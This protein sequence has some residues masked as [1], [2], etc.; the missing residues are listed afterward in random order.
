M[1]LSSVRGENFLVLSESITGGERG[2]KRIFILEEEKAEGWWEFMEAIYD[3]Q[4]VELV[5]LEWLKGKTRAEAEQGNGEA[6][7]HV[8]CQGII[9][10]TCQCCGEEM[11]VR[12]SR[13]EKVKACRYSRCLR[14][15]LVG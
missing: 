11:E 10:I 2:V 9:S 3:V 6:P 8:L 5:E 1:A 13:K 7:V 14:Q 15:R 12:V 4:R